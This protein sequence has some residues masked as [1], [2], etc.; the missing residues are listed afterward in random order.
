[1]KYRPR[2]TVDQTGRGQAT[3]LLRQ[4]R[5]N[6]RRDTAPDTRTIYRQVLG[7]AVPEGPRVLR[8]NLSVDISSL[9]LDPLLTASRR[10]LHRHRGGTMGWVLFRHVTT[11]PRAPTTRL[12]QAGGATNGTPSGG[13]TAWSVASRRQS[14]AMGDLVRQGGAA[15]I[16]ARDTGRDDHRAGQVAGRLARGSDAGPLGVPGVQTTRRT[17]H[18]APPRGRARAR[19]SSNLVGPR[20]LQSPEGVSAGRGLT[21]GHARALVPETAIASDRLPGRHLAWTG[22][23]RSPGCTA[24]CRTPGPPIRLLW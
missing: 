9:D 6:F 7:G 11:M 13:H 23:G 4:Q 8:K 24:V 19:S 17:R 1:M 18:Q 21:E 12:R 22:P 3:I 10:A 2:L 15:D 16:L 20:A 14:R 5:L